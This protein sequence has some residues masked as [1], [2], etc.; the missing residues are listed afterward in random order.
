MIQIVLVFVWLGVAL[1]RAAQDFFEVISR[2]EVELTAREFYRHA[3]FTRHG[4]DCSW[5]ASKASA[6]ITGKRAGKFRNELGVLV[7][8]LIFHL[9]WPYK[10]KDAF[11]QMANR[12]D[13]RNDF[14]K[15]A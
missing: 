9:R 7:G 12:W 3:L 2:K 10:I 11:V 15:D 5:I 8:L 4:R 1:K 13:S 6:I 14:Q